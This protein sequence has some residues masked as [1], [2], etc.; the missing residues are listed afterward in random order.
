[1]IEEPCYK[2]QEIRVEMEVKMR[3]CMKGI[4]SS[5]ERMFESNTSSRFFGCNEHDTRFDSKP[6][7]SDSR[8]R[9]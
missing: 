4:K 6:P 7:A 9:T 1:M 3:S 5:I 2:I 8:L